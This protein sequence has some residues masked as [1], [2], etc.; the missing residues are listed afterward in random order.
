MIDPYWFQKKW[1]TNKVPM[2]VVFERL[3]TLEQEVERLK[4]ENIETT[5][6]LY[7]LMNTLEALDHRI[8]II[9]DDWRKQL[10]V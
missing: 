3:N 5:N 2:D 1:G 9:A 8:D 7:E 10:N 6:I 4:E